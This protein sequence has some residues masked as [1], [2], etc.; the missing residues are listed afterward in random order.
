VG[1]SNLIRSGPITPKSQS[2]SSRSEWQKTASILSG[3][4]SFIAVGYHDLQLAYKFTAAINETSSK[5]GYP[6][7]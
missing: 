7:C 4:H 3:K 5:P 1:V 2:S 6:H